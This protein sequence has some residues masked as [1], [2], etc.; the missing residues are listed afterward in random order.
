MLG[1]ADIVAH[2]EGIGGRSRTKFAKVLAGGRRF[3]TPTDTAAGFGVDAETVAKKLA[4]LATKSW[5]RQVRWGMYIGMAADVANPA[6][7]PHKG[8]SLCRQ[9]QLESAGFDSRRIVSLR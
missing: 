6:A 4:P 3:I 7:W 2:S 9:A 5:V 8:D 1:A